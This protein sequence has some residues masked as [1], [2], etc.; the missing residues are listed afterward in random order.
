MAEKK[1]LDIIQAL[2]SKKN[3]NLFR[4]DIIGK[5]LRRELVVEL[6]FKRRLGLVEAFRAML[7][8]RLQALKIFSND[9]DFSALLTKH[10][11]KDKNSRFE[12]ISFLG[13]ELNYLSSGL[14][15]G[16]ERDKAFCAA[17]DM[18]AQIV[19]CDQYC[20]PEFVK[21][22]SIIIDVGANI[23]IFSLFVNYLAPRGNIYAFEPTPKTFAILERNIVANNL[24]RNIHIFNKAL[25][26]ECGEAMLLKGADELA[27]TNLINKSAYLKGREN[28]F[29]S[30][31]LIS[32]TTLDKFVND[33]RLGSVDFIK[34]DTEGYEK[35]II[36]GAREVIKKFSPV[37]ACSA[38]HLKNDEIEIPKLVLSINPEYNYRLERRGEKDLIFWPKNNYD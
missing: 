35:Q 32:I 18:V 11:F 21:K 2:S 7:P 29:S 19:S 10:F 12:P 20:A 26:D 37:I 28:L 1:N 24:L 13:C 27:G 8:W 15:G 17:A 36:K 22:D 16:K 25:G 9:F 33:L 14:V 34:I 23:G 31:E 6:F 3:R 5:I 4:G 38:Y 30:S